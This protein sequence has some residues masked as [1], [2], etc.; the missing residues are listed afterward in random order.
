M[1]LKDLTVLV[2][3]SV[4]KKR[5]N[6][7]HEHL[8]PC[9]NQSHPALVSFQVTKTKKTLSFTTEDLLELNTKVEHTVSDINL[10][11]DG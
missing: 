4:F 9:T 1:R 2:F 3:R 5:G 11:A 6:F 8:Q 7:Y 10:L